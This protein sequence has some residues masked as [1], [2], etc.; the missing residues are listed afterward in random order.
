MMEATVTVAVV[1]EALRQLIREEP[2]MFKSMLREV[3]D[4][5]PEPSKRQRLAQI[6]NE[7]FAECEGVF[8]KLA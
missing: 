6:V 1:K 5:E 2:D 8:R 3:F 4:T 7:D